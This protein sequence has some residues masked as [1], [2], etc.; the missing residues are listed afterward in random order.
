MKNL[1]CKQLFIGILVLLI[2]IIYLAAQA[3]SFFSVGST[4]VKGDVIELSKN[5][6]LSH[7]RSILTILLCFTGA[8]L[9]FKRRTGGWII[10]GSILL[11][12]LVIALGILINN[13]SP[14]F[15]VGILGFAVLILFLALLFLFQKNMRI[16]YNVKKKSFGS[17]IILSG[18]LVVIYFV[19]Q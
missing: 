8:I 17:M 12:L 5:E 11:L 16:R 18:M 13:F 7:T 14:T 15:S 10:T 19:L 4:R 3:D 2:G 1:S 9:F 6:I